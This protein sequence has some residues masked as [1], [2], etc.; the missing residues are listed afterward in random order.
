MW[1][2]QDISKTNNFYISFKSTLCLLYKMNNFE[3]LKKINMVINLDENFDNEQM[4]DAINNFNIITKKKQ[5]FKEYLNFK[6]DKTIYYAKVTLDAQ[7]P[8][9]QNNEFQ[10]KF[11]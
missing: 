8:I 11:V 5:L 7:S 6:D 3:E 4:N 1:V 9:I 2:K 10:E